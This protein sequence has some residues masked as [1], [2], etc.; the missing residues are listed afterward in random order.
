ME[1]KLWMKKNI[2]IHSIKS[3][4][5][6]SLRPFSPNMILISFGDTDS[7]APSS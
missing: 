6:R 5:E 2:E 4:E 1:G 7:E 3:I